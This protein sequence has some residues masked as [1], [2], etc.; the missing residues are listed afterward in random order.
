MQPKQG[1]FDEFAQVWCFGGDQGVDGGAQHAR[2][3]AAGFEK[4][5]MAV[6]VSMPQFRKAD[7]VQDVARILALHQ[8]PPSLLELEITESIAMD[9]PKAV[10]QSLEALKRLGILIAIDD[11]GTGYSSLGQLHALPIDCLKIDRLFVK[12]IGNE[13]GNMFA[14]TIMGLI[15]KLRVASV[16][17]GVETLEQADFLH[18][19]GCVVAQGYL[20]AKPMPAEQLQE[21]LR[22]RS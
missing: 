20:Y 10:L 14:E 21:W 8:M 11:F 16:A 1:T 9:E 7:F 13:K 18:G 5:K 2:L 6:N 19:L 22:Q 3:A 12:E 15:E 4:L 17:E